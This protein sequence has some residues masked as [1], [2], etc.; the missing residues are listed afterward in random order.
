MFQAGYGKAGSNKKQTMEVKI[1]PHMVIK[2]QKSCFF[3]HKRRIN[4]IDNYM[5]IFCGMK[6]MH[7]YGCDIIRKLLRKIIE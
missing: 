7:M 3:R 6:F 4:M 2:P 1:I 5:I